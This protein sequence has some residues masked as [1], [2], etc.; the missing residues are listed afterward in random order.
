V[1][2]FLSSSVDRYRAPYARAAEDH[3]RQC[4]FIGTSNEVELVGDP[5]GSRRLWPIQVGPVDVPWVVDQRE[6][7]WAEAM[8]RLER[9]EAWHLPPALETARRQAAEAFRHTDPRLE[10]LERW[11][12][13]MRSPF[14]TAEALTQG[15]GVSVSRAD[16]RLQMRVG[17]MLRELGCERTRIRSGGTRSRAWLPPSG[18]NATGNPKAQPETK[19][20]EWRREQ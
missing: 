19:P 16:H 17:S 15:L 20:Q 14:T 9:G 6:Q 10:M 8:V 4:V 13:Q 5:T 3:P 7:L 11:V 18:E 1:K 12:T 2:A